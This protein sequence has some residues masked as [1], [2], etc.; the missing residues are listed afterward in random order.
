ME[1]WWLA[2]LAAFLAGVAKAGVPGLGILVVPLMVFAVGDARSSVALL[3]II[4]VAADIC[5]LI[6]HKAVADWRLLWR[7]GFRSGLCCFTVFQGKS[8]YGFFHPLAH[9]ELNHG[10]CRHGHFFQGSWIMSNAG[11]PDADIK[12]SEVPKL[13]SVA[14]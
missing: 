4:L 8:C 9:L 3:V 1:H 11:G 2:A 13:D 12:D 14:L 6:A 7:F 10:A 5:A